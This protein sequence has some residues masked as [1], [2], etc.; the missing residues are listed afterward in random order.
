[1]IDGLEKDGQTSQHQATTFENEV[2]CTVVAR[3]AHPAKS[4]LQVKDTTIVTD[5]TEHLSRPTRLTSGTLNNSN[6]GIVF[7]LAINLVTYFRKL[8]N[9]NKLST[10]AGFRATV[11]FKLQVLANPMMAGIYRLVYQPAVDAYNSTESRLNGIPLLMSYLP[12][13]QIN[14]SE[15]TEA[16]LKIPYVFPE[17]FLNNTTGSNN[18]IAMFALMGMTPVT[19]APSTQNPPY[20]IWTWLED[21]ELVGTTSPAL[22]TYTYTPFAFV[23]QGGQIVAKKPS[24]MAKEVPPANLSSILASGS[25]ALKWLARGVPAISSVAG[26]TSWLLAKAASVASS[27]GWAKPKSTSAALK[28]FNSRNTYQH[29]VEGVD[30][31]YTLGLLPDAGLA[32]AALGGTDVDEMSLSYICSSYGVLNSIVL[33]N[34]ASGTQLYAWLVGP[35]TMIGGYGTSN[36]TSPAVAESTQVVATPKFVSEHFQ[37]WRGSFKVKLTAGITKFHAARLLVGFVPLGTAAPPALETVDYPSVVWDF[38]SQNTVEMDIP[39][40]ATAPWRDFNQYIGY[41]FVRVLD[42]MIYPSSVASSVNIMVEVAAGPD[43]EV[44]RPKAARFYANQ[45][46]SFPVIKGALTS[47]S[48]SPLTTSETFSSIKQ[49]ISRNRVLEVAPQN[50]IQLALYNLTQSTNLYPVIQGWQRCYAF[51]RG[52]TSYHCFSNYR[53]VMYNARTYSLTDDPFQNIGFSEFDQIHV[54]LPYYS[55][56]PMQTLT[57]VQPGQTYYLDSTANSLPFRTLVTARYGDDTQFFFWL[58]PPSVAYAT[59]QIGQNN[60]NYNAW[61]TG[62]LTNPALAQQPIE[63]PDEEY[64]FELPPPDSEP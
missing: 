21:L 10:V 26:S 51:A 54:N 55:K 59:A 23:N 31:S 53:G 58:G 30:T 9:W 18:T 20:I 46:G 40:F 34:Q 56:T 43:F 25:L 45:S 42:P 28:I 64:K 39:Y 4:S 6:T 36:I 11:C 63:T 17:T 22:T 5:I 50:R 47:E 38:R 27:F 35:D 52:S 37:L 3:G 32:P 44:A 13:T 16:V 2:P 62:V 57:P 33:S 19:I 15:A 41:F 7:S 14:L 29:N 60:T 24:A 8:P 61:L 1:M 48:P 49:L 12:H